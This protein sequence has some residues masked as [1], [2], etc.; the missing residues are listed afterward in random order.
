M[1]RTQFSNEINTRYE[2]IKNNTLEA[3]KNKEKEDTKKQITNLITEYEASK[4][5]LTEQ[6][7]KLDEKKLALTEALLNLKMQYMEDGHKSTEAKELAQQ[8][9]KDEQ[10]EIRNIE[11]DINLLKANIHSIEYQLRLK[12]NQY[13]KEELLRS[14]T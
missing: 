2:T 4:I 9:T 3:L 6:E 11:K 14:S 13:N 5:I 12:Y 10:N 7:Y 8:N 1:I